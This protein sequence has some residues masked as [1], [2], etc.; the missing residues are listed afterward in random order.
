MRTRDGRMVDEPCT[1]RSFLENRRMQ[2][3]ATHAFRWM[4][5]LL[6]GLQQCFAST[7][8]RKIEDEEDQIFQKTKDVKDKEISS[9]DQ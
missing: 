6:Y 5:T 1:R 4:A 8:R 7:R 2:R 9:K 3:L